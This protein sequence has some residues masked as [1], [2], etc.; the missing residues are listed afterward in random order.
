MKSLV[1][2][3]TSCFVGS[4][5]F[6]SHAGSSTMARSL[7]DP[8]TAAGSPVDE[9]RRTHRHGV[10]GRIGY[11]LG[12][13]SYGTDG[14]YKYKP[15]ALHL[16]GRYEYRAF[17]HL[18]VSAGADWMRPT[19][20]RAPDVIRLAAGVAVIATPTDALDLA[21]GVRAGPT[22]VFGGSTYRG[23]GVAVA[24]VEAR[25][26]STP[27]FGLTAG[28]EMGADGGKLLGERA[29]KQLED[30]TVISTAFFFGAA[31]RF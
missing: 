30:S 8:P 2:F 10:F 29:Y 6:A 7:D 28:F 4:F 26:W 27:R 3:A 11:G 19:E 1:G 23:W 13:V 12:A 9:A 16:G 21:F 5:A 14:A 22:W 17:R 15:W 25:Y 31:T 24:V 20:G 18:A